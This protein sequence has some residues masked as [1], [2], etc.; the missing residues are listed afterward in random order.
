MSHKDRETKQKYRREYYRKNRER[1]LSQAREYSKHPI[2]QARRLERRTARP[3]EEL[4]RSAR[5]RAKKRGRVFELTEQWALSK[6]TGY[7]ALTGIPFVLNL[8]RPTYGPFSPSID[9]VD[10]LGGYTPENCRFILMCLN[11]FKGQMADNEF[12]MVARRLVRRGY[13]GPVKRYRR[14]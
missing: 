3:W 8:G 10:P 4:L 5:T 12:I 11:S 7:C 2:V 13:Y 9:R 1:Y 14:S 6:W